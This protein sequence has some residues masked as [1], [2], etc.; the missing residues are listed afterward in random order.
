MEI[1]VLLLVAGVIG[2]IWYDR[3]L[4]KKYESDGVKDNIEQT[5]QT[6]Q[7]VNDNIVVTDVQNNSKPNK[8]SVNTT[9]LRG[10]KMT[11]AK[12][13]KTPKAT[14]TVAATKAKKTLEAAAPAKATKAKKPAA[15]KAKA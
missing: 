6:E 3:A 9:I 14:K 10:R 2:Y 1:L 13:V 7:S 12:K 5:T 4:K 8:Q 11:D 15:K